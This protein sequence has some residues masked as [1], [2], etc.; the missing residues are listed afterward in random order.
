MEAVMLSK[1]NIHE[2]LRKIEPQKQRF[3]IRKFTVGAASVLIGFT[4]MGINSQTVNA[5]TTDPEEVDATEENSEQVEKS[6]DQTFS[7]VKA[8]NEANASD[9]KTVESKNTDSSTETVSADNNKSLKNDQDNQQLTGKSDSQETKNSSERNESEQQNT[10]A[11]NVKENDSTPA[12]EVNKDD[13]SQRKEEPTTTTSSVK[14]QQSKESNSAVVDKN[15]IAKDSNKNIKTDSK[16][17]TPEQVEKLWGVELFAKDKNLNNRATTLLVENPK[18]YPTKYANDN[19]LNNLTLYNTNNSP[20][21]KKV[22]LKDMYI[23]QVAQLSDTNQT[24]ILARKSAD[25]DNV[26]AFIITPQRNR[27]SYKAYRIESNNTLK[28][29]PTNS[30]G[31]KIYYNAPGTMEFSGETINYSGSTLIKGGLYLKGRYKGRYQ[32]LQNKYSISNVATGSASTSIG[33]ILPNYQGNKDTYSLVKFYDKNGNLVEN[34]EEAIYVKGW[35]GQ[36]FALE[37]VSQYLKV[38]KGYYLSNQKEIDDHT[39]ENGNLTGSI[40]DFEVGGYYRKVYYDN[41]GQ[42]SF[43]GLYH[44][45]SPD[46]TMAVSL[47]NANG[48]Q[49]GN[50]QDVGAGKSVKFDSDH[51]YAGYNWTA[52]NPYVT[53]SVH[54]IKYVQLGSITYHDIDGNQLQDPTQYENA[55]AATIQPLGNAPKIPGY[56]LVFVNEKAAQDGQALTIPENLSQDTN[57]VY[58]PVDATATIKFV[59]DDRNEAVLYSDTVSGK[60]KEEIKWSNT[61]NYENK[62][63]IFV[64]SNYPT[65]KAPTYHYDSSKNVFTVHFKHALEKVDKDNQPQPGDKINSNDSGKDYSKY[66]AGTD[67]L[68]ADVSRTIKYVYAKNNEEIAPSVVQPAHFDAVGYVDKVTGQWIDQDK[69]TIE[70]NNGIYSAQKGT[71]THSETP[72]LKWSEDQTLAEVAAPTVPKPYKPSCQISSY[73]IPDQGTNIGDVKSITVGHDYGDQTVI[74]YYASPQTATITYRDITDNKQLGDVV[75]RSGEY[76]EKIDYD[77][78]KTIK[79]WENKGYVLVDN[80]FKPGTLYNDI[81]VD[82]TSTNDYVITLKHGVQPVNPE[83]PGKPGEPINPN[84]SD[85]PKYPTNTGKEDLTKT[86]TRTIHYVYG[87]GP[88]VNEQAAPAV[89]QTTNFTASGYLDKVTGK[90]VTVDENGNIVGSSVGLTWTTGQYGEAKS[91]EIKGYSP[92]KLIIPSVDGVKHDDQTAEVTVKYYANEQA[93]Q[94]IYYDDTLDKELESESANGKYDHQI[95]WKNNPQDVISQYKQLNYELVADKS[96]IP[97]ADQL[98]HHDNNQNIFKIYLKHKT[99]SDSKTSTVKRTITYVYEDGREAAPT[100]VQ[101]L[102]FTGRGTKDLVT[103]ELVKVDEHGNI[104]VN[105]HVAVPGEYTWTPD[106]GD[107]F[108]AVVSRTIDNY[109]ADPTIVDSVSGITH[110]DKDLEEKVVYVANAQ[111]ATFIYIDDTTKRTLDTHNVPGKYNQPI[112]YTTKATIDSYVNKG[113]VLVSDSFPAGAVYQADDTANTYYIHLKHGVQ[114]VNP[115]NPGKP[116]EPINPNDSDGPKYPTNTGKED[117]TKTATRTIH[118]VYGNG[119]H[120]NEQAAPAVMQTT[121]FT[122]SGYLDKVTGKWVTVDENG[123]IVGSSVGLTWTTG[124]YGEAKSP[125][126]KGYSPDKLIIPSVDGVKH[127]DQTAE[128]TVKY[129]ANEQ[130]A[131]IIYYD[132]TLDKELES[133]SANGKYDHQ[134]VW[135]NNPQDVI[136]QYKQLNYELVA[137]KSNIPSADQLYH[138][139]NNQ[140]IFKIYLKHKTASDSKTSTVKRTITYVYEDGRE[141][142]P[143]VVQTLTFTGRGTKDLVTGELVKVDEHGNIVVNNHVAVPG[144]YT[145]TPD[146]GDTFKTVDSP[147]IS[148]YSPDY[149]KIEKETVNHDSKDRRATVTYFANEATAQIV[150]IDDTENGKVLSNDNANGKFDIAINFPTKPTDKIAS[151]ESQ[152]YV[153]VSNNF[154]EGTKFKDNSNDPK[155]NLFEVHLKHGTVLVTP[156]KP[157]DPEQPINPNDPNS[158]TYPADSKDLTKEV[159]R[160]INYY[161]NEVGGD[162]AADTVV[163]T[164]TFKGSGYVDK[165]TGQYVLVDKNNEIILGEDGKPMAGHL[166]WTNNGTTFVK[167]DSPEIAGYTASPAS[168]PVMENVTRDQEPIV[169]NVIYTANSEIA[170]ITYIDDVTGQILGTNYAY[171]YYKDP[172]NFDVNP[173]TAIKAYEKQGYKQVNPEEF[174]FVNGKNTYGNSKL[175]PTINHFEVHFTHE[176]VLVGPNDPVTPDTPINPDD[177]DSPTYPVDAKDL[178]KEVTR[179]I[180]YYYNEVGGD[181][182]SDTVIQKV[183]F[184]GTGYVDKVTGQ[185]VQGPDNL[186]AGVITWKAVTPTRF[187]EVDSPVIYGYTPDKYVVDAVEGITRESPDIVENVV[188]TPVPEPD[189]PVVPTTIKGSQTIR[190]VDEKGK[191]LHPSDVQTAEFTNSYTFGMVKVPVIQGY[192]ATEKVAGGKTVTEAN[193]HVVVTVVY[194]KIGNIIPVD[195]DNKPI[196][197]VPT[198]P[199][200]NDP[201]DPTKVIPTQ[202]PNIPGYTPNGSK[203]TPSDPTKDTKVIYR[204]TKGEKPNKPSNAKP[205]EL[206]GPTKGQ[207]LNK[208]GNSAITVHPLANAAGSNSSIARAKKSETLPQTGEKNVNKAGIIGLTI[209]TLGALF[210]LAVEKKRKSKEN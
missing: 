93:A 116:G 128:V 136:S 157:G 178:T 5:E 68:T 61:P 189:I 33:E 51:G 150:Y 57:L 199:Y 159:T 29:S 158:P 165:V 143:T 24:A 78:A 131:Q 104:V 160:T 182:A 138:H 163:Q 90:W 194:K 144:E 196:P 42:I 200:K 30:V 111:T 28:L 168:I 139:D 113:Y 180:N 167:V 115:E 66:P 88:H 177:P 91:P 52:R 97:S 204:K 190:F 77:P 209:A 96:N 142:A 100:V 183:I 140:N 56:K 193:P 137:D 40:S 47:L 201:D 11:E 21:G 69:T 48:K 117:L 22:N 76:N 45:I 153:L 31:Y 36:I 149:I 181:K 152:G 186:A 35:P 146:K 147:T 17:L 121:N 53:G 67:Q 107:T 74:V 98:Y 202:V 188:Y 87:N 151:Y 173:A 184:K 8:Q 86:A 148:G 169:E 63:Y 206:T 172:I 46:G 49:I 94:I 145:W 54:A 109:T 71:L 3:S 7:D 2:K 38:H 75:E 102:T 44:Q 197:G 62:G 198:P 64:S 14:G 120:V 105:N 13:S 127:D 59:D 32:K 95:V 18:E 179:T 132:D 162:K 110:T 191:E 125:E 99:A 84:D 58:A 23:Y 156:D 170:K 1:N 129:Y 60:Y 210:G 82:P 122:A 133:E 37:N 134:I 164:L 112:D 101:T 79:S 43:I 80:P 155:L 70:D 103:G 175:N 72:N 15:T 50:T 166:I 187:E 123:N 141:A 185:L 161:H 174:T 39:D 81:E 26:Y 119:P 114:P 203:V 16:K 65:D 92:D 55:T 19:N 34:D 126:I 192:V 171:G 89:M 10:S 85:G 20:T 6:N 154:E 106:K 27:K 124:Q 176:T 4:F 108:E 207:T 83:N 12:A 25:D 41:K 208:P 9:S 195:E 73:P 205:G 135:K 130:A 118:Y